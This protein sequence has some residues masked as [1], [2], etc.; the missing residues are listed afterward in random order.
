MPVVVQV[1]NPRPDSFVQLIRTGGPRHDV[2]I[3]RAQITVQCWAPTTV[4][5]A[6][7]AQTVRAHLG[8]IHQAEHQAT[9]VY[10][11]SELGGPANLPD[12]TSGSAR[13][14][15]SVQIPVRGTAA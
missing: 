13:Y 7:L 15:W 14:S 3:D 10:P 8:V 11:P 6:E 5:A 2:V 4:A 12:P 1:P 9:V